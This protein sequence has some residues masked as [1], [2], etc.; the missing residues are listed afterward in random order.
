LRSEKQRLRYEGVGSSG[1]DNWDIAGL[2]DCVRDSSSSAVAALFFAVASDK[3]TEVRYRKVRE[4]TFCKLKT[5][6]TAAVEALHPCECA[7][8]IGGGEIVT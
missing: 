1:G 7:D 6:H 2:A 3:R 5:S 8:L 4:D